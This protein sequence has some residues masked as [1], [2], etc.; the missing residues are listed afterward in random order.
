LAYFSTFY[1]ET[2]GAE[3]NQNA[4]FKLDFLSK[5]KCDTNDTM[6]F[7]VK[8]N[9]YCIKDLEK[10]NSSVMTKSGCVATWDIHTPEACGYIMPKS[11]AL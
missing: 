8:V 9:A 1:N 10:K 2:K 6:R 11:I 7:H 4:G 5:E 3:P